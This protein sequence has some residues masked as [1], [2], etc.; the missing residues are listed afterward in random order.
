[1]AFWARHVGT[2]KAVATVGTTTTA[3]L[4]AVSS[5][6]YLEEPYSRVDDIADSFVGTVLAY[7]HLRHLQ[8]GNDDDG[9]ACANTTDCTALQ[10]MLIRSTSELYRRVDWSLKKHKALAMLSAW[11]PSFLST[12][13]TEAVTESELRSKIDYE[14]ELFSDGPSSLAVYR[15]DWMKTNL[16][17]ISSQL[18][19]QQGSGQDCEG[20]NK[21][22]LTYEE[23]SAVLYDT[24]VD[25]SYFD[26]ST[27]QTAHVNLDSF[28]PKKSKKTQTLHERHQ[29]YLEKL[30]IPKKHY[31][32]TFRNLVDNVLSECVAIIPELKTARLRQE[33]ID[34]I[35]ECYEAYVMPSHHQAPED[36]SLRGRLK[37]SKMVVNLARSISYDKAQQ[38]A[39]HELTHFIQFV[40][41][42][43]HLYRY[44]PEMRVV[45]EVFEEGPMSFLMEGGAELFV[46][47]FYDGSSPRRDRQIELQS[48][49]PNHILRLP[50]YDAATI[51]AIEQI[52]WFG[53]WPTCARIARDLHNGVL[54]KETA[55]QQL[56]QQ[57]LK[58]PDSWPNA[59]FF[60]QVGAYSLGYCY[61]KE[62]IKEY[63]QHQAR[64][65]GTTVMEEYVRMMKRPLT[66]SN[67]QRAIQVVE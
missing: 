56:L 4:L 2:T 46:E 55:Q 29:K 51:S 52:S 20:T 47:L 36:T 32:T 63:C 27:T 40:L 3:V 62:L 31:E 57:A 8:K 28:L 5:Y 13:G 66:P 48:F 22:R 39:V 15:L 54:D 67:M 42:E 12:R 9:I 35:Q 18:Q 37:E 6:V 19:G 44:C 59:D 45:V 23:E 41:F 60:E 43:E 50:Y 7:Q 26:P 21:P 25:P 58:R 34:D 11:P 64:N 65:N 1:M 10:E 53:L 38:L 17:C 30:M 24:T 49:I 14:E 16:I 61:G 33:Y